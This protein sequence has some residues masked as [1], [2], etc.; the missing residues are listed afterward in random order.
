MIRNQHTGEGILIYD[1]G[2]LPLQDSLPPILVGEL[3]MFQTK[4]DLLRAIVGR[5]LVCS[6]DQQMRALSDEARAKGVKLA[7][8]GQL[9]RIL[10]RYLGKSS[11]I[12]V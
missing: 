1:G 5:V 8:V 9:N 2:E 12:E 11:D 3:S 7:S 10:G 6:D 4:D